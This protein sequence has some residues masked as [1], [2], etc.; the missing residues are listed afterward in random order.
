MKAELFSKYGIMGRFVMH[1]GVLEERKNIRTLISAFSALP[2]QIIAETQLVFAANATQAQKNAVLRQ[3][4]QMRLPPSRI[5]FAGYVPDDDLA[6]LYSVT[7]VLVMPSTSEG[8]GLPLLEAMRCGAPVLGARAT[9]I[10]EVVGASEYLFDPYSPADLS[11]KMY[12][13]LSDADAERLARA[14]SLKRQSHFSWAQTAVKAIEAIQEVSRHRGVHIDRRTRLHVIPQ[15][16]NS[17]CSHIAGLVETTPALI[18][19]TTSVSDPS[20]PILVVADGLTKEQME[21]VIEGPFAIIVRSLD[22]SINVPPSIRYLCNGYFGMLHPTE[23]VTARDISRMPTCIYC[24]EGVSI[25]RIASHV[26]EMLPLCDAALNDVMNLIA[27]GPNCPD[28]NAAM[29]YARLAHK[30]L[31]EPSFRPVLYVD[32]SELVHRDARTGIQ[33]VVRSILRNLIEKKRN[34][35]IEPIYRDGDQFRLARKFM[36]SFLGLLPLELGDDYVSFNAGDTFLGLDLDALIS[37]GALNLLRRERLRGVRVIWVVYDILPETNPEWFD[38]PLAAAV[39]GWLRKVIKEADEIICISR[40]VADSLGDFARKSAPCREHP[41]NI[42]W[43][44]LGA[45]LNAS[46]PSRGISSDDWR[47]MDAMREGAITFLT[48]GTIEPRKGIAKLL[49][50]AEAFWDQGGDA[51]FVIVGK[52]GWNVEGL[53]NRI[54]NHEE[55]DKRL[56]WF[57]GPTDETLG[58]L[59]ERATAVLL[60]SEG[61]GFGLPLVEAAFHGKPIIARDLPVFREIGGEGAYYFS[62]VEPDE[63]RLHLKAW[64][65][66]WQRQM[67]PQPVATPL[68]WEDSTDELF[69]ILVAKKNVGP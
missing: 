31:F 37:P 35:R 65:D 36:M 2:Q 26:D 51:Q 16:S 10:P 5:V 4:A 24:G 6:K 39:Q 47:K 54:R 48:V 7:S 22:D 23:D 30:N 32:I 27:K 43:W 63:F 15:A 14:H 28:H 55:L 19:R 61:E 44:H 41:L 42:S 33:R 64:I 66:L 68:S 12:R 59:Y 57:E 9:S 52:P 21:C 69:S 1:T 3:A 53:L 38:P 11:K 17:L 49:D 18:E 58:L 20:A 25:D 13:V 40:S 29:C 8:F 56:F 50:G 62:A 67:H 45:D 60:P 46:S 34:Y